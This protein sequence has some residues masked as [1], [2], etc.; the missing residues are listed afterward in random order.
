MFVRSSYASKTS[1]SL[2][3]GLQNGIKEAAS[4]IESANDST[5]Q[6]TAISKR[7]TI[8]S[9]NASIEAARS[10]EMGKG[11]AVVADEVK[12]LADSLTVVSKSITKDLRSLTQTI[13]SLNGERKF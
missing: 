7:Q 9:L 8:L 4:I 6:I 1:Q 10:G 5:K 3:T 12:M 2:L 11:F 13:N